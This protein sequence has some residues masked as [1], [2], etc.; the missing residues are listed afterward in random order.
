MISGEYVARRRSLRSLVVHLHC[1]SFQ[2]LVHSSSPP[3]SSPLFEFGLVFSRTHGGPE[4]CDTVTGHPKPS[5]ASGRTKRKAGERARNN[6]EQFTRA[7]L[8]SIDRCPPSTPTSRRVAPRS[9][10]AA[11]LSAAG[12]LLRPNSACYSFAH[13]PLPFSL[14]AI[15]LN[16]FLPFSSSNLSPQ[17]PCFRVEY[18]TRCL[19]SF[20]FMRERE[21]EREER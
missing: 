21:I 20:F 3:P 6:K 13:F 16:S 11:A 4:V 12:Q 5:Q 15:F 1:S 9:A 18:W 8:R 7:G 17:N 10:N 2:S 19:V 14:P